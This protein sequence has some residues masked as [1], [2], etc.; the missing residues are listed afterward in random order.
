[1]GRAVVVPLL[2]T[3]LST[4]RSTCPKRSPPPP[5]PPAWSYGKPMSWARA[6]TWRT[7]SRDSLTGIA[8]ED[9]VLL[10]AVGSSTAA[11]NSAVGDLADR[12]AATRGAP[13]R[14]GFGTAP[15]R[16]GDVLAELAAT[17][18]RAIV[19][20][21]LFLAPGLLL[22]PMLALAAERDWPVLPPLAERAAPLVVRRYQDR[23]G[24]PRILR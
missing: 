15:P 12:L 10:Y 13:V 2:F 9:P 20:L 19:I 7:C 6:R 8:A 1:M 4:P 16:A 23:A 3:S 14:A 11:A 21:P 17:A 5:R 24:S 18:D 22:D